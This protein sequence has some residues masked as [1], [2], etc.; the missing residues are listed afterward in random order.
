MDS[1]EAALIIASVG[2]VAFLAFLCYNVAVMNKEKVTVFV[3]DKDGNI[4]GVIER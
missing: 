2:I 4:I 1:G 3:R